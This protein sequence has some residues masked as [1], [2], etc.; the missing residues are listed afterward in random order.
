MNTRA[1]IFIFLFLILAVSC[2]KVKADRTQEEDMIVFD[3]PSITTKSLVEDVLDLNG[4]FAVYASRYNSDYVDYDFM[5]NLNVAQDGTYSGKYYWAPGASH[6]F[7]ALYPWYDADSDEVD[8]GVSYQTD[9]TGKKIVVDITGTLTDIL[10]DMAIFSDPFVP[11]SAVEKI[12]FNL[13]HACSAISFSINNLSGKSIKSISMT[14][15][16]DDVQISGL[17]VKGDLSIVEHDGSAEV[18]WENLETGGS[19]YLPFINVDDSNPWV[20][21]QQ[22][23]WHT[24]IIV[25]QNYVSLDVNMQFRIDYEGGSYDEYAIVLSDIRTGDGGY[26]Y[27]AGRHYRYNIDITNNDIMCYVKVVPWIEDE[28]IVLE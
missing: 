21:G 4:G 9:A 14:G 18:V 2:S 11:G 22:R 27:L 24:E 7:F 15:N 10:Y 17:N 8:K 16:S 26:E 13:K 5:T 19:L 20:H 12:K 28:T 23:D 25:P 1:R 3:A 6:V